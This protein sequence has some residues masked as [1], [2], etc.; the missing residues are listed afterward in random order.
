MTTS[1][2]DVRILA[3]GG[4]HVDRRGRITGVFVPGASNPGEMHEEVGGGVFNALRNIARRGARASLLSLRGGDSAGESVARAA[5]DEGIEDLSAVF[6]DRAT[7]SYTALLTRDGELLA[8]L[9]AMDLY[10]SGFSR[11][12]IRSKARDAVAAAD[13]V[14]C[15]ANLT[16]KA[17]G[18]LFELAAGK[19]VFAIAISPVKAVRLKPVMA[20]ISC[21]FMNRREASALTGG[22]SDADA[23][24]M[25]ARLRGLG[26]ARGVVTA[27]GGAMVAYDAD[28]IYLAEPPPPRAMAD[29]TGAG[30][31]LAGTTI[32]ALVQGAPFAQALREGLAAARLCIE[33]ASNV[34]EHDPQAFAAALDDVPM[35]VA[36]L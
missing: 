30:D 21:L 35:P 1:S 3:I 25:V 15:D 12:L 32:C 9:A 34:P 36:L 2:R 7:P 18:K 28:G 4:A 8:G 16:E 5:G 33:T 24:T 31:A 26:L 23:A 17:L 14:L 6:L 11:Q 29:V 22:R 13:A 27:G 10:D 20:S 19:P